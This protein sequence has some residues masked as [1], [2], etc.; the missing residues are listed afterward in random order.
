MPMGALLNLH[1]MRSILVFDTHKCSDV[2]EM[3]KPIV[4]SD[5]DISGNVPLEAS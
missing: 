4:I 2:K 1:S 5:E 3:R